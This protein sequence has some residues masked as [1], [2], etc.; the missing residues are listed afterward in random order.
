MAKLSVRFNQK[1]AATY[2]PPPT[3]RIY[4][5]DEGTPHLALCLAASGRRVWYWIGRVLGRASRIKIG[6][7]PEYPVDRARVEAKRMTGEVSSGKI[8]QSVKKAAAGEVTL[9]SLFAHWMRNY[10]RPHKKTWQRD[11]R[12]F[13]RVFAQWKHRPLSTIS[14]ED[15][16][17]LHVQVGESAGKFAANEMLK[18]L[19]SLYSYAIDE[20]DWSG[21][22]PVRK[23]KRYRTDDRDRFLQVEELPRFFAAVAQ[24]ERQTAKDFFL[25]CL[26][27]GARRSNVQS[28]RWDEIDM[29]RRTWRIPSVKMKS[30]DTIVLPLIDA[31]ME[32]LRRRKAESSSEWVLPGRGE[33]GHYACPKA[34]WQTLLAKSGIKNLRIHDLR[35]TL[36][37]FQAMSG[38]S[39]LTIAKS[40]G[41]SSV[42][43]TQIYARLQMESTRDSVEA[44]AAKI[45][46]AAQENRK[47]DDFPPS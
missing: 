22:N 29:N 7:F 1:I 18:L 13:D 46:K 39:L 34:S 30:S 19:S 24:L 33:S 11:E 6:E 25:L 41:H 20:Y 40:L 23:I 37:S 44:A 9:G 26:F 10:S 27:T 28:M 16:R 32:I 43:A 38:A 2:D 17:E 21:A 3:G 4:V 14:R 36:A 45:L 5:Y 47:S 42:A 35:R 15:V 8:P 12:R 31:A